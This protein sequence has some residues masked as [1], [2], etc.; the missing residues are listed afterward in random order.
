MEVRDISQHP[1]ERALWCI[2]DSISF[3]FDSLIWI[4]GKYSRIRF[5]SHQFHVKLVSR[6]PFFTWKWSRWD[7]MQRLTHAMHQIAGEKNWKH[8]MS[9]YITKKVCFSYSLILGLMFYAHLLGSIDEHAK[10]NTHS[11]D[12][13]D[14]SCEAK[15]KSSFHRR[16]SAPLQS[17]NLSLSS[18]CMPLNKLSLSPA[19]RVQSGSWHYSRT[20]RTPC[21]IDMEISQPSHMKL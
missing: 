14:S 18:V 5:L 9:I 1:R 15:H 10:N 2:C 17:I 13:L 19:N 12:S 16:L 20:L 21:V 4:N 3:Q 7:K 11:I 6:S 8:I